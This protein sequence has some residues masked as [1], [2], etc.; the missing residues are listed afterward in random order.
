MHFSLYKHHN[1]FKMYIGYHISALSRLCTL[2]MHHQL[3]NS[4]VLYSFDP[5]AATAGVNYPLL[6]HLLTL[7][8]CG[9]N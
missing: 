1:L 2:P 8:R 7:A 5:Q 9:L 4:D 3:H 6:S